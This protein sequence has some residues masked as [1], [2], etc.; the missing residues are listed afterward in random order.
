MKKTLKWGLIAAPVVLAAGIAFYP[1]LRSRSADN[2]PAAAA[3]ASPAT[4]GAPA[5]PLQIKAVI[6][7][8]QLLVDKSI[9]IG[10][11]IPDE[12]VNLSFETSGKITDIH[13]T[14][15]A[16]VTRGDLLAKI[17]DRPLQ[18]QLLSH[19]A[20]LPLTHDRLHRQ[21]ALLEKD[22]VSREA[23]Q[24]ATTDYE[25]LLADI[26]L[27]RAHIDQ[28]ELRAPF[29]GIIGLRAV[30]P[31]AYV[32]P[33]TTVATLTRITPIKIQFTI[34]ERYA[35][36]LHPGTPVTFYTDADDAPPRTATVY[37]L[38]S[39]LDPATHTLTVRA[40]YP[41]ADHS[42][43]PGQFLRLEIT[44]RQIPDAL[45][46]P[47][48]AI[49]PE[50]GQNIIYTYRNGRA[51]PTAVTTG[52]RTESH[53]QAVDGLSAGDTLITTGVMQLRTGMAVEITNPL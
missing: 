16:H 3:A 33:Q 17:N 4:A 38:D 35:A 12:E 18:A 53:V 20:A 45:A 8:P 11:T 41:N 29:D 32:T 21:Q 30:S 27:T 23:H 28:T 50:M 44:H 39:R 49:I 13:F 37:A 6:L 15:G 22:A 19:Q 14:E 51:H 46:V 7:R 42:L 24:Q 43:R 52:L 9:S 48:E 40:T 36:H 26:Q 47:S 34:P 2:A 5:Q 25:R 1:A 31:G 10:S